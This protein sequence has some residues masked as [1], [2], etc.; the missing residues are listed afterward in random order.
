MF[1]EEGNPNEWEDAV[2][3]YFA[4][5]NRKAAYKL[6]NRFFIEECNCW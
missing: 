2:G 5:A 6:V 3:E 1:G 4:D